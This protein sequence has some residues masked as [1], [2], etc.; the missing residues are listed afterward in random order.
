MSPLAPA[1]RRGLGLA[2]LLLLMALPARSE[3][4][5]LV[6]TDE[7]QLGLA[8]AFMA[9]GEYY[10]A[11]TEYKTFLYFFPDSPRTD[12]AHLQIGMAYYHGGE[13]PQAI[14][15]FARVRQSYP[16]DHFATA[17]FYEGVCRV[18]L[19]EPAAAG[20][21][22]ER[23][24]AA[25]PASPQAPE[26]L[27]GLALTALDRQDWAAS[28]QA[29]QRLAD[30]YPA[31]P[32]S[33]AARDALPLLEVAESRPRKSPALAGTLS[34]LVPGSGYAYAGRYRDGLMAFLVNG[35]FIAGTA[36]AIDHDNVP[37]AALLGGI[38]LPFYLGNIYGAV[39][40]A[41]QWNLSIARDLR[42][43][44]VVRLDFHY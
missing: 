22:F 31:D 17:A 1:L 15:A 10:R 5:T 39:N 34:A 35:L 14:A 38:G 9:E 4:R 30:N 40:A 6:I 36:V 27:A 21:D 12:Y 20:A 25:G 32:H 18:R 44:L 24:L 28:R 13:C 42:D 41:R 16:S 23:V 26:A 33:M 2:L 11:I 29:L 43:D 3:P 37:A 7:L 19:G 8:E